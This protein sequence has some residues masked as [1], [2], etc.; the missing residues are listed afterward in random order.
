VIAGIDWVAKK[1][2]NG[3]DSGALSVANLSLGS[4]FS[5][6]TNQAVEALADA[7]VVVAVAAGNS[8]VSCPSFE[9]SFGFLN[10]R[11]KTPQLTS[12][13]LP[14]SLLFLLVVC[15]P[16]VTGFGTWCHYRWFI[17]QG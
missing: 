2:Q 12:S 6:S 7:G 11:N 8:N 3:A 14:I 5:L 17:H 13:S 10:S 1:H 4:F 15:L 9:R 16:I